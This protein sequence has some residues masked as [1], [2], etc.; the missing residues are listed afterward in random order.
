MLVF[1]DL[2]KKKWAFLSC[3]PEK[4]KLAPST[5][6][7]YTRYYQLMLCVLFWVA[8]FIYPSISHSLLFFLFLPPVLV[9]LYESQ[10][11]CHH[12]TLPSSSVPCSMWLQ[13]WLTN[14]SLGSISCYT[15]LIN[16]TK[17]D[18]CRW[19]PCGQ[20]PHCFD[21]WADLFPVPSNQRVIHHKAA[22]S[23]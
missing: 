4:Q 16:L 11:N 8:A 15:I 21:W 7:P 17:T 12:S 22:G 19:M 10:T 1:A 5:R 3:L 13:N 23:S 9:T 20:P 2:S 18:Q 6:M 14:Y